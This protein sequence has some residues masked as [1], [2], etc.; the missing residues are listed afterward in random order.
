MLVP[1]SSPLP[2]SSCFNLDYLRIYIISLALSMW[3]GAVSVFCVT[4]WIA[5]LLSII[6]IIH[7]LVWIHAPNSHTP[8]HI[9]L[10]WIMLAQSVRVYIVVMIVWLQRTH[11]H[12][13]VITETAQAMTWQKKMKIVKNIID[14]IV[15][16]KACCFC[17]KNKNSAKVLDSV[18][19]SRQP[20]PMNKSH[21]MDL[22]MEK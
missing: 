11:V 14:F 21:L 20:V 4:E 22:V 13:T 12:A 3:N 7:F 19:F 17:M 10:N 18:Q 2:F 9:C 5:Q 1:L 8:S 16:R 6:I 15:G